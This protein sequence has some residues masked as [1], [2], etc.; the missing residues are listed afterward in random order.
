MI[1]LIG[2]SFCYKPDQKLHA[3][4]KASF[5]VGSDSKED[6]RV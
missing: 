4:D 2:D 3:F 1:V 5:V 6:L